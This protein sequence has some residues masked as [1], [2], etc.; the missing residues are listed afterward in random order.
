MCGPAVIGYGDEE[1][2]RENTALGG[3][4]GGGEEIGERTLLEVLVRKSRIH[5]ISWS[6]K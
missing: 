2:G 4:S 6:S 1:Q 3:A 5:S